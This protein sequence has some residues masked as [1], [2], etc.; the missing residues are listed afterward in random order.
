[1]KKGIILLFSILSFSVF[2]QEN[3]WVNVAE[4]D[5]VTIEE[6]VIKCGN[7]ELL[8]F[9]ISNAN[10]YSITISWF[11]EVWINDICKQNG[12]IE[13]FKKSVSLQS[14]E[15]VLGDC[16]FKESFYI[17]YKVKRGDNEMKLTFYD[18]KNISVII[19]K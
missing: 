7:N 5:G 11:E 10:P 1:M 19:E 9:R 15:K 12:N 17:G 4:L 13:E 18:L 16:S 3:E 14:N 6:S 8:T 2:S